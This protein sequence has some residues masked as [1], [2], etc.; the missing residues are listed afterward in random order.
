[1]QTVK[2]ETQGILLYTSLD[3]VCDQHRHTKEYVVRILHDGLPRSPNPGMR[4]QSTIC[5]MHLVGDK[6]PHV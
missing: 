2:F 4:P 1:M 5:I 6:T 3:G